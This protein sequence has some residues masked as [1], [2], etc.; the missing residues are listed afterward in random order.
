MKFRCGPT[1]AEQDAKDAAE[2]EWRDYFAWWPVEVE[3]GDC[4]WLETIERRR[5]HYRDG[6]FALIYD[7]Y[8][9]RA[10]EKRP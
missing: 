5:A 9:Y 3:K 7:Q 4:R 6:L 8:E 1:Q 2:L 10:K